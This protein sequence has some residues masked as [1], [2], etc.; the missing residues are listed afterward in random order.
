VS[1]TG[2][3][4]WVIARGLHLPLES[5]LIAFPVT[6]PNDRGFLLEPQ[7]ERYEI[8]LD[9]VGRFQKGNPCIFW[10]DLGN[11]RG[12]CG[13]YAF[14]PHVC[15][16]YPAYQQQDTII[17]RSD[18]LCP[19]GS[20]NLTGIDL[21]LFRQRLFRFRVEQDIYSCIVA[22]WNRT[23]ERLG[24][25][26]GLSEY[27]AFLTNTYDAL[28][29]FRAGITPDVLDAIVER[30][31]AMDSSW[32]NPLIADLAMTPGDADWHHVLAGLRD[33]ID[34]FTAFSTEAAVPAVA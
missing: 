26:R 14:R 13:I 31:G 5:F 23:S 11:D 22:A 27:Y 7:G 10:I 17:L 16:T 2:Y 34:R 30:W 21:P 18:V 6:G 28:E 1:I 24:V 29:R 25:A 15:Q 32:P 12:R 9:K 19:T 20:W 8:A 33:A 4:A 3:D